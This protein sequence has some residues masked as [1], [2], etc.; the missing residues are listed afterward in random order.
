MS[1]VGHILTENLNFR[2]HLWTFGAENTPK[3]WPFKTENNAQTFPKQVQNNFEKVHKTTF[4]TTKMA[5][6]RV[7]TWQKMSIFASIFDIRALFFAACW[8]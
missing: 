7:S 6:I 2:V 8:Y 4:S 5:K 3:N 1:K